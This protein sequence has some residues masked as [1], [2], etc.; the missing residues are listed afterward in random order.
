MGLDQGELKSDLIAIRV[1]SDKLLTPAEVVSRVQNFVATEE[2]TL[3]AITGPSHYLPDYGAG[4]FSYGNPHGVFHALLDN[5]NQDILL[6]HTGSSI[7][8]FE[9]WNRS[10]KHL[11]GPSSVTPQLTYTIP[12]DTAC[13]YPTQFVLCPNGIVIIPQSYTRAFFYDGTIVS[14]LGYDKPPSAPSGQGPET[15]AI[16]APNDQGYFGSGAGFALGDLNP[17]FGYGRLGFVEIYDG[18]VDQGALLGSSYYLQYQHID[19][20]GNLGPLSGKSNQVA[21][22]KQRVATGLDTIRKEV[23]W[24]GIEPGRDGTMGRILARSK[25]IRNIPTTDAFIVPSNIGGGT[26][27]SFATIPDNVTRRF[28]DNIPDES[29]VIRPYNVVP[30]PI[31][32][33]ACLA[34]GR[35]WIGAIKGDQGLIK[36]SLPGRW[37]TFT[38]D[39]D[40]YPDPAGGETTGMWAIP[41]GMLVFTTSST[42]IVIPTDDGLRYRAHPVSLSIGCVAPDTIQ[43]L[44]DGRV[45]WLGA[46]G[47]YVFD[48]QSIQYISEE[49][50]EG[51]KR[52]NT[53]RLAQATA[54][55]DRQNREYR[56]YLSLNGTI[57]NDFCYVYDPMWKG[58]R[59]RADST[60]MAGLC[61]T[62]DH[63]QYML[64]AGSAA[65]SGGTYVEGIYLLDHSNSNF[66][67]ATKSYVIFTSWLRNMVSDFRSSLKRVEIWLR[68][69]SSG[70]ITVD[71]YRDWQLA[72]GVADPTSPTITAYSPEQSPPL[73]NTVVL[74]TAS[75]YWVARY[76]HWQKVD[77][78]LPSCEVFKLK[79]SSTSRIELIGI[80]I[81]ETPHLN[82]GRKT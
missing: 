51:F 9:G 12:N 20:F 49:I 53:A 63:R 37:G 41:G 30:I 32:K 61:V 60:R 46:D 50:R 38:D 80:K 26:S 3:L 13:R 62:R 57:Y 6:A 69:T 54:R 44:P 22:R 11:I 71:A 81:I 47:F 77:I 10:W 39:F 65:N 55:Y 17:D 4:M 34:L 25:D 45:I 36:A 27:G 64:G 58:W 40:I 18:G 31:F 56:C 29:L 24:S 68:N 70:T 43:N 8:V 16:G 74:G 7:K 52:V 35:L 1:E 72:G 19:I 28:P 48:G 33:L 78:Y 67:P 79:I 21:W 82:S 73:Y 14:L 66:T 59:E 15:S 76:P 23:L 75:T 5:G 2:G 42:F